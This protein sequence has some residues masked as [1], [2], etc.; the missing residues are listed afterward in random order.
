MTMKDNIDKALRAVG[1]SPY[2]CRSCYDK[3][4][5]QQNLV[6]RTHYADEDTLRYFKA[7]ILRGVHRADGLLFLLV[8]S[9]GSKSEDSKRNKRFNVFDVFGTIVSDREQW[10]TTTD[11]ARKAAAD[12]LA[13]F[14]AEAHTLE[15]LR[16]MANR[17]RTEAGHIDNALAGKEV[18][19]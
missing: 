11:Q 7:R 16:H 10:F 2:T 12:F 1:A 8:E 5:A 15:A 14:D 19:Q 3:N 9:V 18:V 6:G 4:N 17:M 13:S